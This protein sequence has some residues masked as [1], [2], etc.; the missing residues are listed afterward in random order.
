MV[1]QCIHRRTAGESLPDQQLLSQ[2]ADLL[3]ELEAELRKLA[4]VEQAERRA[5]SAPGR[6][7]G[8][9]PAEL[10]PADAFGGYRILGEIHRGGQG[11][12]YRAIQESTQRVVAIKVMSEGPF[13]GQDDRTRF[14]REKQIL[15][16]FNHPSIVTIRDSGSAAGC[17]YFVMDYVEG[18]ALDAYV[19]ARELSIGQTLRLFLKI[20]DAVNAA[21]LRGVIHR[22][23]KPGNIR[24]DPA[25]EPHILDFGLA[26]TIDRVDNRPTLT[27]TGQFVGSLPWASPEQVSGAHEQIDMRT[28]V[29]SLGVILYQMLT[30]RFPYEVT[31]GVRDVIGRVLEAEPVRPRT[32]RGQI[33]DEV[34]TIVLKCLAKQR[35][36]RYQTA[37][38]LARDIRHY[39]AGEPIEAKRD[40]IGY[41][42]RTHLRKYRLHVAIA[43]AFVVVVTVGF[44]TSLGFWRQ[45]VRERDAARGAR[46]RAEREAANATAANR[47]LR[48]V[49][50]LASPT[51][52]LGRPITIREA[53]DIAAAKI[54]DFTAGHP[55]TEAAVREVVG[56]TYHELGQFDLAVE[57]LQA[58]L[59]IRRRLLGFA[60]RETLATAGK[61]AGAL[62]DSGRSEEAIRLLREIVD[63]QRR[64]LG[65]THRDTLRSIN[66]LAWQLFSD[67][68]PVEAETLFRQALAGYTAV[69]GPDARTVHQ[70][71]TNLAAALIAQGRLDEAGPLAIAGAEGL[72]RALGPRH[73]TALYARNI[74]AWYVYSVGHYAEAEGLYRRIVADATEVLGE[75]HPYRLFWR[76]NLAWCLLKLGRLE[77]AEQMFREV[78]ALER[79]VLATGHA[80]TFEATEGLVRTLTAAG[81]SAEAEQLGL[82]SHRLACDRYGRDSGYTHAAAAALADLYEAQGDR[83]RAAGWRANK[84]ALRPAQ[85]NL[86]EHP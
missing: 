37:G 14:E 80:Y 53:V 44:G 40:S 27:A 62:S 54:P 29:Y 61:L 77:Q 72:I 19:D 81:K 38:E 58:A 86:I 85:A 55:Q 56:E 64:L 3:P 74:C 45:A 8:A 13:A 50:S 34:E 4:L 63:A 22:D 67:R 32:V 36:R 25:G 16:R 5:S 35:E 7:R 11:V 33:D 30:G 48:E 51:R 75:Q 52:S 23:L 46:Q 69:D 2:H 1:A 24:V 65:P 78:L 26:R 70:A 84:S 12:V 60:Q 21:H 59:R 20:C 66:R 49:L 39:L 42:L 10:P 17:A 76:G 82:A 68:R 41:L 18:D 71:M 6:L 15:A 57:H 47:F 9:P 83:E 73:P 28:D 43:A 31:G 79:Q